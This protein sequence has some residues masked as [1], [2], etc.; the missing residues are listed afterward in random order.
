MNLPYGD[1]KLKVRNISFKDEA[2]L[3]EISLGITIIPPVYATWYAY[4]LYTLLILSVIVSIAYFYRSKLLLRNSL[5][6]ERRDKLQKD[7]INE[8][9]MRF[10]G[11]IS[12]ELKTPI[13][14]DIRATGA[15]PYVQLFIANPFRIVCVKYTTGL[16][17]WEL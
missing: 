13:A 3:N 11:N 4:L 16:P 5:E 8:S 9:K 1:Y 14:A 10:L 15:Y 12:H 2:E 17:K 7:A 6:L